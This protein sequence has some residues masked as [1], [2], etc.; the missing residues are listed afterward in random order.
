[1]A[2][3]IIYRSPKSA[4]DFEKY[5]ELRWRILRK[6]WGQPKGSEVK[7]CDTNAF[8][9]FAEKDDK[10]LGVGCIHKIEDGVG[11]IRFMG[12]DDDYQKMGI[13]RSIVK[14]L[15]EN[16]KS[17]NWNKVRL[18]AR[19]IAIDF[20]L[21]LGYKIVSDGELLFGVIKHKIMEKEL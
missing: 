4:T 16:A 7:E 19:E 13:G 1:M 9:I 14:L 20:Y 5:Y 8:H 3:N 2:N 12:V 15:E 11:R 18:W 17:N 6:P 21:N 10:V